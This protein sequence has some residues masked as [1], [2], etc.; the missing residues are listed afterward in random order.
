MRSSQTKKFE[1]KVSPL[2]VRWPC[3]LDNSSTMLPNRLLIFLPLHICKR[4]KL[5]FQYLEISTRNTHNDFR[6]QRKV[7]FTLFE[8]SRLFQYDG[9]IHMR[10]LNFDYFFF[11]V[12]YKQV[13]L[14]RFYNTS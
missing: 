3:W 9:Q 5:D 8:F 7:Q 4:T 2:E 1:R 10:M 14:K 13:K 12:S 11:Q 6:I